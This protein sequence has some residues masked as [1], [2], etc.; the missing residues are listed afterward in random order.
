MYL[1]TAL[2]YACNVCQAW[3]LQL[4]SKFAASDLA[5][6]LKKIISAPSGSVLVR[7]LLR[8]ERRRRMRCLVNTNRQ[9]WLP[10]TQCTLQVFMFLFAC[11]FVSFYRVFLCI[12]PVFSRL[13][14]VCVCVCVYFVFSGVVLLC[15][16]VK[17]KIVSVASTCSKNMLK[18]SSFHQNVSAFLALFFS[19]SDLHPIW[20]FPVLSQALLSFSPLEACA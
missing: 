19:V 17:S 7:S 10:D 4:F 18:R 20:Y 8:I 16:P 14:G 11:I 6:L 2:D 13:C 1:N 9:R 5:H 3:W 15:L 12:W